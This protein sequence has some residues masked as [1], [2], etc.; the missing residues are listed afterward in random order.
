MQQD[1]YD[2][3]SHVFESILWNSE[4][5][6]V[7]KLGRDWNII[8]A[9]SAFR[10][11]TG[12]QTLE[13]MV[14]ADL[15]SA[16]D[17]ANWAEL[18]GRMRFDPVLLNYVRGEHQIVTLR[19]RL[20]PMPDFE[21]LVGEPPMCDMVAAETVMINLNNEITALARENARKSN[22][23]KRQSE[24][25]KSALD[26]LD[27]SYWHLKKIQEVLPIC[28][29]CNKVKNA[30]SRWEDVAEYLKNNCQFLT[31]GLCPD[32]ESIYRNS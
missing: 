5:I 29:L 6:A 27:T 14:M 9:N 8:D 20:Y 26:E 19:S 1:R 28:I 17:A 32:C 22:E 31:H 7:I 16:D 4:S 18:S 21:L 15:L 10:A 11:V 30:D 13:G 25:L 12:A 3:P 23:L 24:K 2:E